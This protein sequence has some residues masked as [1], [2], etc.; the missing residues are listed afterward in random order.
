MSVM[1][2]YEYIC[3]PRLSIFCVV[4]MGGIRS[5]TKYA[6]FCIIITLVVQHNYYIIVVLIDSV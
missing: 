4:V 5:T 6:Q 2:Y 1:Y 3:K